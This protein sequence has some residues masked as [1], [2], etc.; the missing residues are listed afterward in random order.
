[1]DNTAR[2]RK[3]EINKNSNKGTPLPTIACVVRKVKCGRDTIVLYSLVLNKMLRDN[4]NGDD[5][6]TDKIRVFVGE[7]GEAR[8]SFRFRFGIPIIKKWK[9][10]FMRLEVDLDDIAHF[11]IQNKIRVIYDENYT[12][13]IMY[14]FRN[15]KKGR[16]KSTK[17]T[18]SR[19][20]TC[21]FRQSI[22]NT[23][24]LTVREVSKYDTS[25]GKVKVWIAYLC[26]KLMFWE[27]DIV[28]MYEKECSRYEESASVLYE[29]L[30][31][32]GYTNVYYL[33]NADNPRIIGLD[34]K[35][36]KGFIYKNSFKHL[37]YFF[38]SRKFI[39]TETLGHAIQLR[40][41]NRLIV[42]KIH[43]RNLQYIFLQHG[44]M[45]MISLDAGMRSGFQ[46]K[47]LDLYRVVVSSE[48][49]AKHFIDLGNF[50]KEELYVT[51]L[52]KFD[53]SYRYDYAD[54]IV[55]M[56]TWRRWES[57]QARVDF[58]KTNYYRMM[59]RIVRGIP[60]VYSDK[61]VVLPH[62]LMRDAME[63]SE[64]ELKQY[65]V[66][67][68]SYDDI[69][70]ECELLITDYSSIAYDAF[71]RGSNVLFY[72]EE[73][74]ECLRKYGGKAKLM[75]N[76]SNIFG[77]ICYLPSQINRA[78]KMWY[79][80]HQSDINIKRYREIVEYHDGNNTN[81]IVEMLIKDRVL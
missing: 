2:R 35:Y 6:D 20:M 79:G 49:E 16:G 55:V 9:L 21:Y 18:I 63:S 15:K 59:E 23:V 66:E 11:D 4:S 14:D 75:I 70:K 8:V 80:K 43:S 37:V 61:I 30:R 29:K 72:W 26:S 25:L 67:D 81:R 24:Y 57:N 52:A 3:V 28:L 10:N 60:K 48:K 1:M 64:C 19:N 50:K 45:Y 33:V 39:G 51:G 73:K 22:N 65:M 40:A 44:V 42:R 31:E 78:V 13:R 71:Y 32:L 17:A 62:P 77:D 68:K 7:C 58:R 53:R 12:G 56:P 54:K 47:E 41:A 69:L 5:V 27:N 76:E 36:N 34:E 46:S 38:K 74:E